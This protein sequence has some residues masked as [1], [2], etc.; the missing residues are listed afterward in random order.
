MPR[1]LYSRR[2][3]SWHPSNGRLGGPQMWPGKEKNLLLL[4]RIEPLFLDHPACGQ[5]K[6]L[7]CI[8]L[9]NQ[10][11]KI[12]AA[13][14]NVYMVKKHMVLEFFLNIMIYEHF[15]LK[16]VLISKVFLHFSTLGK[17]VGFINCDYSERTS[18]RE[19]TFVLISIL[20]IFRSTCHNHSC[21][22]VMAI[23]LWITKLCCLK[24]QDFSTEVIKE[25]AEW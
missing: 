2:K 4:L 19:K 14:L 6:I 18:L 1:P 7:H 11:K 17:V 9:N 12:Q 5:F 3:S 24:L 20:N 8:S 21:T 10:Y 13:E 22:C 15:S 16:S 25:W 23:V